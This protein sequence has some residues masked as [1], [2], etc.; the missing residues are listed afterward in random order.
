MQNLL[1]AAFGHGLGSSLFGLFV[2]QA[3]I[4]RTFGAPP[5]HRALGGVTIGHGLPEKPVTSSPLP[6]RRLADVVHQG[7][8]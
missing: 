3:E 6:R 4:L 7:R 1:L 2:N 8:W 5:G